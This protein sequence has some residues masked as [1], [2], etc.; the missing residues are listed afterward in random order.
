MPRE[1]LTNIV[2]QRR[3]SNDIGWDEVLDGESVAF[4]V[5]G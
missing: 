1:T 3:T 4:T 2:I 5:I